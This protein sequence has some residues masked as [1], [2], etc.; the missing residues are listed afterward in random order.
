MSSILKALEKVEDSQ[1]ARRNGGASGL[2]R[3]RE[4]RPAWIMPA[5]IIGGAA[6]AALV[7]FAAMGGFSKH[8]APVQQAK[9]VEKP[10][11]V[12]VS[13]LYP[14]SE[15]PA[16]RP[17]LTLPAEPAQAVV[18]PDLKASP[19]PSPKPAAKPVRVPAA[20]VPVDHPAFFRPAPVQ[21][22]TV[23]SAPA[24]SAPLSEA[25]PVLTAEKRLPEI[26]VTGIAW[27]KD[28]QSSA[29]I[30]NGRSVVQGS[31]VDGYKVEQIMEDSV[32][33]SGSNGKLEV[34]L[35]GGE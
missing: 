22:A 8:A 21:P 18:V 30:V 31:V 11:P 3:A 13:P 23:Q 14:V 4:R 35:G 6:V 7:T 19:A 25:I 24:M 2:A 32:R 29:A 17:E 10:A 26:R 27:Q 28:S 34:P 5:G 1:N 33:F 16:T 20:V 9:A 15:V 12:V